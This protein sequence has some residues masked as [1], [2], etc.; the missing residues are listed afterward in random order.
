MQFVTE[1]TGPVRESVLRVSLQTML[2]RHPNLRVSLWDTG[3]PHPV[4]IVPASVVLPWRSVRVD[5]AEF[6]RLV[7]DERLK[8]FDLRRGPLLRAVLAEL[9]DGRYRLLLTVHHVLMDGWSLALFFGELLAV[10]NAD[11]S[12]EGLGPVR[13]YRNYIAWLGRQDRAATLETWSRELADVEPLLL[14]TGVIPDAEPA[15]TRH[16][17]S[18]AETE[19]FVGWARRN[20]LTVNTAVEFAWA[21]VLGL[22]DRRD[23]VFGTTVSGAPR[24]S[25]ASTRWSACSSTPCPPA[26][27]STPR[28]RR[29]SSTTAA[30]CS[31]H[32]RASATSPT[33]AWPTS[34]GPPALAVVRHA[35]RVRERADRRGH[36]AGH[37]SRRRSVPAAGDGE[38]VALP[39]DC[40]AYPSTVSSSSSPNPSP[41]PSVALWLPT[42][43]A[44]FCRSVA[45]CPTPMNRTPWTSCFRKSTPSVACPGRPS[46]VG[47]RA[48]RADSGPLARCGDP[49]A[50]I[51]AQSADTGALDTVPCRDHHRGFRRGGRAQ[52]ERDR[53]GRR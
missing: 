19:R 25:T 52:S 4:Q 12:A 2:D 30:R 21:T 10:Y 24:V 28:A 43:R 14:G 50:D 16:A 27:T 20:G 48:S 26:S 7:V 44:E 47:F 45:N 40:R 11:G 6:D 46:R 3:V 23:V 38:P 18:A 51:G 32:R 53:P 36:P 13:P 8:R 41:L 1:I 33:W 15:R 35:V 42:S 37:R 31:A 29:A 34:P 5:G 49:P 22:T 17:L 39:A 9:P